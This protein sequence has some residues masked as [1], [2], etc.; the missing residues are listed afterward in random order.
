M[1][2]DPETV[3]A[4]MPLHPLE[5]RILLVLAEGPAHGYRI[6]R[7]IER[8]DASWTRV[9]PANLYRRIRNMESR[10]LIR[11]RPVADAPRNRREFELTELGE[12]VARAEA[13]RLRDLVEDFRASDLLPGSSER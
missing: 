7:Q 3:A 6:V 2:L 13:A 8:R 10:E 1:P 12:A 5:A 4:Q 9:F 11:E